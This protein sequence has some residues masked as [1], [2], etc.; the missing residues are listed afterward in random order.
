[1]LFILIPTVWLVILAFVVVLCRMAAR[2]DADAA[3]V[4]ST[5][6]SRAR[7]HM[8]P[9]RRVFKRRRAT[10]PI[11]AQRLSRSHLARPR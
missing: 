4:S 9:S 7:V 2:A 10:G 3:L 6:A 8:P 1:M 5:P 11:A